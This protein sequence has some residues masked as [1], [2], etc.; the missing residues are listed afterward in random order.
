MC[1][2]HFFMYFWALLGQNVLKI[3]PYWLWGQSLFCIRVLSQSELAHILP[4]GSDCCWGDQVFFY[5]YIIE[6]M[7]LIF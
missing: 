4:T 7:T 2:I 6:F 5:T 1:L 3:S